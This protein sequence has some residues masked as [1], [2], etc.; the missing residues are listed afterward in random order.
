VTLTRRMGVLFRGSLR[1]QRR[2]SAGGRESSQDR[3]AEIEQMRNGGPIRSIRRQSR[4]RK[5]MRAE[6]T[7][8]IG[9]ITSLK[10]TLMIIEAPKPHIRNAVTYWCRGSPRDS[11]DE[12]K[13]GASLERRIEMQSRSASTQLSTMGLSLPTLIR[14]PMCAR[15]Y[16]P[17][18][19]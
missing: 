12:S 8:L 13:V 7:D 16:A 1:A 11:L 3:A 17:R 5:P 6:R 19:L 14:K 18:L 2:C 15:C 9:P 10:S 4:D